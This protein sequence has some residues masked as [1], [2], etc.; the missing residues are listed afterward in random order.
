VQADEVEENIVTEFVKEGSR[1]NNQRSK[2]INL[3]EFSNCRFAPLDKGGKK[4]QC[5]H[6][7]KMLYRTGRAS[8]AVK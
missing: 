4:Y 3:P 7:Q 5:E 6:C 1:I 8:F 2:L